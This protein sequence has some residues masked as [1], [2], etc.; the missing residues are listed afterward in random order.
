[1]TNSVFSLLL[2]DAAILLT[3]LHVTELSLAPASDLSLLPFKTTL[4]ALADLHAF[5]SK[6]G[7]GKNSNWIVHKLLFYAAHISL[8]PT[9]IM[10]GVA[11]ETLVRAKHYEVLESRD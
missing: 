5:F 2:R 7:T 11:K 9:V 3:P 4:L 6:G 1:M 10:E 8:T